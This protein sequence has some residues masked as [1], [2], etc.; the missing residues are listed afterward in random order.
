MLY[1]VKYPFGGEGCGLLGIYFYNVN[2]I[3]GYNLDELDDP[4]FNPF[5]TKSSVAENERTAADEKEIVEKPA[6][7]DEEIIKETATADNGVEKPVTADEKIAEKPAAADEEIVEKPT[8]AAYCSNVDEDPAE[9]ISAPLV[10]Q[11]M[12]LSSQKIKPRSVDYFAYNLC[13]SIVHN[14]AL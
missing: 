14:S 3:P 12:Q 11:Q 1:R 13:T 7:A 10:A 2:L 4:N 8:A 9:T 6:E 5:Q